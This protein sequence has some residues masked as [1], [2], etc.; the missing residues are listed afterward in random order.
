M[1]YVLCAL[2]IRCRQEGGGKQGGTEGLAPNATRPGRSG[3]FRFSFRLPI[4]FVFFR[5]EGRY[6]HKNQK[7]SAAPFSSAEPRCRRHASCS[8]PS[9]STRATRISLLIRCARVHPP[10]SACYARRRRRGGRS[11][12]RRTADCRFPTPSSM[13]VSRKTRTRTSRARRAPAPGS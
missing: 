4:L 10:T 13:P 12:R 2:G 9:R 11:N 7:I 8:R 6:A 3:E 1:C 5:V